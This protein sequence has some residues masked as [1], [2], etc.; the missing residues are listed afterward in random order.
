MD[1]HGCTHFPRLIA[2]DNFGYAQFMA[3]WVARD[4]C[5]PVGKLHQCLVAYPKGTKVEVLEEDGPLQS[6]DDKAESG[7]GAS[8]EVVLCESELTLE[9]IPEM[10]R[11]LSRGLIPVGPTFGASS[12]VVHKAL[13]HV[14]SDKPDYGESFAQGASTGSDVD[15]LS[16]LT[17]S[18]STA[19]HGALVLLLFHRR[20]VVRF[21]SRKMLLELSGVSHFRRDADTPATA[22]KA[23]WFVSL[24]LLCTLRHLVRIPMPVAEE[25]VRCAVADGFCSL[26]AFLGALD[27]EL[28][29]I[30]KELK[31]QYAIG[32]E[33]PSGSVE[34]ASNVPHAMLALAQVSEGVV[35]TLGGG[36]IIHWLLSSARDPKEGQLSKPTTELLATM[37]SACLEDGTALPA[38]VPSGQPRMSVARTILHM[39]ITNGKNAGECEGKRRAKWYG[40][41]LRELWWLA[42]HI[43]PPKSTPE[44]GAPVDASGRPADEPH[45]GKLAGWIATLFSKNIGKYI[46]FGAAEQTARTARSG[47]S[48]AAFRNMEVV[49]HTLSNVMCSLSDEVPQVVA[50]QNHHNL[51]RSI[52]RGVADIA[53]AILRRTSNTISVVL[54]L[55]HFARADVEAFTKTDESLPAG[56]FRDLWEVFPRLLE[57]VCTAAL[58]V[59][60]ASSS[61]SPQLQLFSMLEVL[62]VFVECPAACIWLF[63]R[64]Q[65]GQERGAQPLASLV[66][67]CMSEVARVLR[68]A[69][70]AVM[71]Q[72][73]ITKKGGNTPGTR[74]GV[75]DDAWTSAATLSSSSDS[76]VRHFAGV[77]FLSGNENMHEVGETILNLYFPIA[78][79]REAIYTEAANWMMQK[80]ILN[81][82]VLNDYPLLLDEK[83]VN[84]AARAR[85]VMWVNVMSA[86]DRSRVADWVLTVMWWLCALVAEHSPLSSA[87]CGKLSLKVIVLLPPITTYTLGAAQTRRQAADAPTATAACSVHNM[88]SRSSSVSSSDS[89]DCGNSVNGLD[90]DFQS[91][92]ERWCDPQ[93]L[94]R[95]AQRLMLAVLGGW[96]Y[97]VPHNFTESLLYVARVL[98]S[99]PRDES[100]TLGLHSAFSKLLP[101]FQGDRLIPLLNADIHWLTAIIREVKEAHNRSAMSLALQEEKFT[102]EEKRELEARGRQMPE[103]PTATDF[104]LS[105]VQLQVDHERRQNQ[106]GEHRTIANVT[107]TEEATTGM[108]RPRGGDLMFPKGQRP[109]V[110][111]RILISNA[112]LQQRF[113][114]QQQFLAASGVAEKRQNGSQSVG[115]SNLQLLRERKVREITQAKK[116]SQCHDAIRRI[117]GYTDFLRSPPPVSD[118]IGTGASCLAEEAPVIPES[119]AT[120]TDS[121]FTAYVSSFL[122]HIAVELRHELYHKFDEMLDGCR[123]RNRTGKNRPPEDIVYGDMIGEDEDNDTIHNSVVRGVVEGG[124]RPASWIVENSVSVVCTGNATV[125]P[126][127]PTRMQFNITL[128]NLGGEAKVL[129]SIGTV[130]LEGDVAVL[131]FPLG[132]LRSALPDAFGGCDTPTVWATMGCMPKICIV[133]VVQQGQS[134]ATLTVFTPP[135]SKR[136][137]L[138]SSDGWNIPLI[139]FAQALRAFIMHKKH[140]YIKRLFPLGPSLAV[141]SAL[142]DVQRRCIASTLMKPR[143]AARKAQEHARVLDTVLFETE[144]WDTFAKKLLLRDCLDEF[145]ARAVAVALVALVSEWEEQALGEKRLDA[146]PPDITIIEGPPG[147][148]KTQTIAA[149]TI[150]L[151]KTL[152]E[153]KRVLLC[154]SSNRA[155]DEVLL[156]LRS[157]LTRAPQLANRRLLRVGVR[158]SVDPQVLAIRPAVF[159]DDCTDVTS[160]DAGGQQTFHAEMDTNGRPYGKRAL[161]ASADSSNVMLYGR[162]KKKDQIIRDASVVCTTIGSIPQ[163]QRFLSEYDVVV[164]DEASQ[165]TEPEALLAL[166][167]AKRRVVLVGD[168]RQL[169]PTVLSQKSAA[170]GLRRSLLQRLLNEGHRPFTLLTQFRM[171]PSLCA[172]PNKYFYEGKLRTHESVLRRAIPASAVIHL[173]TRTKLEK[174][175][176]LIFVDVHEGRMES[177]GKGGLRGT[178]VVN[179]TEAKVVAEHV[180]RFRKFLNLT[181]SEFAKHA[182]II[183]FYRAQREAIISNLTPEERRSEMQVATTDSFQG[184]ERDFVFIS[185]VRAPVRNGGAGTNNR[186]RYGSTLGFLQ[187]WH[188]INVALTRARE[189][190]IVFGHRQTFIDV[191]IVHRGKLSDKRRTEGGWG[192]TGT[193][194]PITVSH[195]PELPM[196]EDDGNSDVETVE[197]PVLRPDD[198]PLVFEEMLRY[199]EKWPEQVSWFSNSQE[200]NVLKELIRTV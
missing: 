107:C 163:I 21:L 57:R 82:E 109:A 191:A 66:D 84:D 46:N 180:R 200:L 190:C 33:T 164:V 99:L 105:H 138:E 121:G 157:L 80:L 102:M 7:K 28:M 45:P 13:E 154:A 22:A 37:L 27:K 117:V 2:P 174:L 42:A 63:S 25:K 60:E 54:L 135:K 153:G 169:Q 156:R 110:P 113:Q 118:I 114:Q 160:D 14:L 31:Q 123:W 112:L 86:C 122:P 95:C 23:V 4:P 148:G 172:F 134:S 194:V 58:E 65:E 165:C 8:E 162:S 64:N 111:N 186:S 142:F 136:P 182:G 189:F 129:P 170:C 32:H 26:F 51:L 139:P 52:Q 119:F 116:L 10:V 155:V 39:V 96:I 93:L 171:H 125:N 179:N 73:K 61:P 104:N 77:L 3:E 149:L 167:L 178:S 81:D 126:V 62:T 17:A 91:F 18:K 38:S 85:G 173:A 141:V 48:D 195:Q 159:L 120:A 127:D 137:D 151:L 72:R 103:R 90:E 196:D 183:T 69:A 6:T 181:V 30:S 29:D 89:S 50:T 100:F 128:A 185:C 192:S 92:L 56:C 94:R 150:N 199:A 76:H 176:R 75:D 193:S 177:S 43:E 11:Q 147:T 101:H 67:K 140:F 87:L 131:M 152:Q 78:A 175:P 16:L 12:P 88:I 74:S 158:E 166:V 132:P 133:T 98:S 9:E 124:T 97:Y 44:T 187:D 36:A 15:L 34:G 197:A 70:S 19:F 40:Q 68:G 20:R 49:I 106:Q 55:R 115:V 143:L 198:D 41:R 108:K 59:T 24:Q 146:A 168:S 53:F 79:H 47:C 71:K 83:K 5:T 144:R 1:D 184:K 188:R 145:Q 35:L 161:P 130:L